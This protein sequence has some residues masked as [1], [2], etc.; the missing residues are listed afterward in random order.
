MDE[1]G[2][3]GFV[4]IGS[5]SYGLLIAVLGAAGRQFEKFSN[6]E[7]WIRDIVTDCRMPEASAHE[8]MSFSFVTICELSQCYHYAYDWIAQKVY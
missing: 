2:V 6:I 5:S 3:W 8:A 4:A 7:Y 1:D